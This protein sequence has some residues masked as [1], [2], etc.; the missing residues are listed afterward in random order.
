M[1]SKPTKCPGLYCG[2]SYKGQGEYTDCGACLRGY[3][4]NN[5]SLCQKCDSEPA[6]YDWLYL[7]FMAM[8]SLILHWFFIDYTNNRKRSLVVLHISALVETGVAVLLT[9]LLSEPMGSLRVRS[10]PVTKLEDWYTMLY[11]PSPNYTTTLYCTQEIVY[12]LY[13]MVMIYYAFSLLMLMLMRPL[14]SVKFVESRGTKSMYAAL[15]FLPILIVLQAVFGGLLYYAFPYIVIVL[16][17]ITSAVKMVYSPD[18]R[19]FK[20]LIIDNLTN[21]RNLTVLAGHWLLH[22]YGIVSLTELSEPSF[23]GPLIAL[24][25]FP[26]IFYILTVR[27][28]DPDN[29]DKVA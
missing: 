4:P 23:H 12:P 21:V 24:V 2:R 19:S 28:T 14:I 5:E 9:L 6:F 29:L 8:L 17:L 15:Y 13:T 22:A 20:S 16:S 10:C 1:V 18:Q 3:Q 26:V 27:F 7:G 25:P 11:N